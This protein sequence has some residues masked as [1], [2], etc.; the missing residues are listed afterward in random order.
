MYNV[1]DGV[2]MAEIHTSFEF[3]E[4]AVTHQS[5]MEKVIQSNQFLKIIDI[6]IDPVTK[7][8]SFYCEVFE[9]LLH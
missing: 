1:Y 8:A 2:G 4:Q 3:L 6:E 7:Q 9:Y 5:I